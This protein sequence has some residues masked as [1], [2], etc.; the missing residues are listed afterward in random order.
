MRHIYRTT[1]RTVDGHPVT[2]YVRV[3]TFRV[4]WA[5]LLASL[6][7]GLALGIL[8]VLALHLATE[9]APLVTLTDTNGNSMTVTQECAD[10]LAPY[11]TD[12]TRVHQGNL[13]SSDAYLTTCFPTQ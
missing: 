8:A 13:T 1:H 3:S 2:Q 4:R 11:R 10:L 9:P 6:F 5:D 7:T 12:L